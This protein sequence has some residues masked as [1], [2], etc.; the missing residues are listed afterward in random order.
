MNIITE[1][2]L[3]IA[4][5]SL[6][7]AVI[8]LLEEN[9]LPT[10]DIDEDKTLF[11]L[12]QNDKVIGTG[13]LELFGDCAL[14][15]SLSVRKDWQGKGLGRFIAQQLEQVCG[16][17]GIA[18]VYLLT[19]TAEDFFRKKGYRVIDRA[20]APLS[21]KNSSEFTTVCSSTGILM[22]KII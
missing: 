5:G 9:D 21:I 13:G 18:N 20:N 11:A 1:H 7:K 19:T 8:E 4:S 3:V 15:R 22:H 10:S 16:E 14:L 6:K 2:K 12:I 17:S